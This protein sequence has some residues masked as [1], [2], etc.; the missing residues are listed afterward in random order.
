MKALRLG[1]LTRG[2]LFV[3]LPD[4]GPDWLVEPLDNAMWQVLYWIAQALWWI[5]Q[6]PK[7]EDE[8]SVIFEAL[9]ALDDD[10]DSLPFPARH[11]LPLEQY[12]LFTGFVGQFHCSKEPHP[13]YHDRREC[14]DPIPLEISAAFAVS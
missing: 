2:L 7:G 13:P 4:G 3:P 12:P 6:R 11:L 10:L 9:L 14:G 5:D 1:I 8:Q